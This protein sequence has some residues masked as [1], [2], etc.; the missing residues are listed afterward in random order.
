MGRSTRRSCKT[1]ARWGDLP[2]YAVPAMPRRPYHPGGK[3]YLW[4]EIAAGA[5][6]LRRRYADAG[7]GLGHR[8]AILAH[9]RPE[10]FFHWY[11]LNALGV[12]V[13]PINPDYREGEIAYLM[14][15]SEA[16]LAL[17]IDSRASTT[18]ARSRGNRATPSPSPPS[19]TR[20]ARC[21]QAR[22]PPMPGQPDHATEAALL[23]T[24]GTT[25]RPKGC[26]MTNEYFH[27]FGTFY[28]SR[29]GLYAM[30]EGAERMYNPLP[31]HHANALSISAQAMLLTGGC[32]IFP[33]R[34]HASTWWQD[35][36]ETGATCCHMQ[37]IIPN[38]LLKLPPSGLDRAHHV[39]FANCAGIEPVHHRPFE[40]RFGF[41]VVEMWSMSEVG[42]LICDNHEPRRID[43]R[44]MG[45]AVPG[46]DAMVV[47]PE[48]RKL[49]DGTPGEFVV[50]HSAETPR[51]GFFSGYLKDEKAT[52]E[53]WRGGWFHTGDVARRDADGMF[54]FVDRLKHIIRRSGENIAA[55]EIEE[56]VIA[57]PK[58]KQVAV[59]PVPDAMRDEEIM[60]CVVPQDGVEPGEA[61][62]RELLDDA[63]GKMA[64]FKAPAWF[65]F[66][67]ELPMGTSAKLVKRAIF[68]Q[69][70]DPREHPGAIDLR[71]SSAAGGNGKR[72]GSAVFRSSPRIPADA[73]AAFGLRRDPRRRGDVRWP[74]RPT[75]AAARLRSS[76]RMKSRSRAGADIARE[77]ARRRSSPA[78]SRAW[79]RNRSACP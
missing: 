1:V 70:D 64:Y 4:R 41:P 62:A 3:T 14:E 22:T 16:R 75:P 26:V 17:A 53:A 46:C 67:D 48:M 33:D 68:A 32:L 74:A 79:S 8:V 77:P 58:V 11:A 28:L 9:Q 34:F 39:R 73:A 43:E 66:F 23:Y 61:L 7:Y 65:V 63:L 49:P 21:P 69:N 40:E 50:R 31:L 20:R 29:G 56:A 19:T 13:V 38:V 55:A 60:A 59:I 15:H 12:S 36:V 5:E 51:K 37:G 10:F 72:Q 71:P 42:R 57:H 30:R 18:S 2:A 27:S 24:S 6:E 78:G 47:D 76:P 52:D 35:L 44:A 45:R 54:V 25:G